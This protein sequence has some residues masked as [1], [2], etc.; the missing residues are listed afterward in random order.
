M[1]VRRWPPV[2]A[3][4]SEV[5]VTL[6][7]MTYG[8]EALGRLDGKVVFVR[9]GLA[10]ERVRAEILEDRGHFARARLLDVLKPSPDR[11]EPRC[12]YFGF[13]ETTCGGCHWQH[14]A[15]EAQLHFKTEIVREQLRRI[16]GFSAAPGREML[17]SPQIWSYRNQA[18]FSVTPQGLIGFQAARTNRVIPIEACDIVE[19]PIAGWLS[20][21]HP[22]DPDRRAISI[23]SFDLEAPEAE[24]QIRGAVF[25]VSPDSFFQVNS[26]LL[27]I[28]IDQVLAGLDLQGHET[29]LDAYCGVGLFSRFIA[30]QADRVIGIESSPSAVADAR[31]N[32]SSFEGVELYAGRVEDVL[33]QLAD[34]I[35]AVVLDPPRAGCGPQ[36]LQALI[37]RPIDRLVY[38]SCDPATLAR[39]VRQLVAG[40][41]RLIEI[42]PLDM[43]PHTYHIEAVALMVCAD[44]AIL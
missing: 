41:Y 13:D 15:Y 11:T 29:V 36:V 7:S 35:D 40:G 21:P 37:A 34:P 12:P 6:E 20:R 28:L 1:N 44:R 19:P 42:Q 4:R 24:F 38:V 32:L 5:V 10:G 25:K 2:K 39:D 26:S 18:R 9:G 3:N 8:G 30:P 14:L 31:V 22:I 23:R 33:P 27:P 17:P 43:F 16:G